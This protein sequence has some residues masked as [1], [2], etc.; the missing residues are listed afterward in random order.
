MASV[1]ELLLAAQAKKSPFIS[2]LEGATQGFGQA[3]NGALERTKTLIELDEQ[4]RQAEEAAYWD[5]QAKKIMAEQEDQIS[6]AKKALGGEQTSPF[7]QIRLA[8]L[9]REGGKYAPK[10]EITEPKEIS[11]TSEKYQDDQ[12]RIRIGK[13]HPHNG[14]VKS[15]DDAIA[16]KTS[17]EKAAEGPK[18]L[19][20][21]SV[22]ALNEGKT[23][24]RMLPDVEKAIEANL[25]KF[26]PVTGRTGSANPYNTEAQ[27]FDAR[28]RTASQAFGR[29]ME[30][31]VLRKED[32]EKYRKMFP[33]AHDTD[34]VKINK[35]S[36][37]RR[38]L[39]EKYE[40]D[41]R[42]LGAS[43]YD[44]SGFEALEVPPSI[45]DQPGGIT[46]EDQEAIA[47]AKANPGDPRAKEI[48]HLN[49][50][51]R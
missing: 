33:Q 51:G 22:L 32:E 30:G 21:T 19:P 47:W 50:M 7:P 27:T 45:F 11:Y 9:T 24:A 28:M 1:Q 41:R 49:G 25:G 14:L 36:I 2:L 23:V 26:G 39:A 12:G 37:V 29:F 34:D 40:D 44:V 31:G 20:P 43:G 35:L 10:F 42:T 4:R 16:P 17:M 15:P 13:W 18:I 48:L 38:M 3:Q 6:Q 46:E 8:G 5:Q